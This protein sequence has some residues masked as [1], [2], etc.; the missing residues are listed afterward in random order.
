MT[1]HAVDLKSGQRLRAEE[2][3][4][5]DL[6]KIHSHTDRLFAGLL[7]AQWLVCIAVAFWV[8]PRAWAGGSSS[9]HLH[10][11]AAVVL[12]AIIT[13]FPACWGLLRPGGR[14]TRH[15][16]AVSQM[17][18]SALLIHLSGGRI[19]T[20]FHVF[21]SLALLAAYRDWRVLVTSTVVVATDHALRG[22]FW[23]ESV[24][25]VL[26]AA[27]WRT[28]EHAAWVVFEDIFLIVTIRKGIAEMR[29]IAV[30]RS[31]LEATNRQTEQKVLERTASLRT[32]EERQRLI[33][34]SVPHGVVMFDESGRIRLAN[35]IMERL[36]GFPH[37]ELIGQR[38]D[39]LI[40]DFLPGRDGNL[41]L[42]SIEDLAI[43]P[44]SPRREYS[45]LRA[46]GSRLP[47]ELGLNPLETPE[48]LFVVAAIVDISERKAR[49]LDLREYA[50]RLE[51][52]NRDLTA[53]KTKLELKNQELDEFTYVA[54]HDLQEPI[55][56][57][58]SFS[59][60]LEQD[61]G[62]NLNEAAAGDL[63][64][65]VDAAIRM[66]SLV[67]DLLALSRAGCAA[68][69]L[70]PVPVEICQRDALDVLQMRIRETGTVI[71]RSAMPTVTGDRTLLTQLFQNLIENAIKFSA[72][73]NPEITLTAEQQDDHWILG[74]RDNGIGMKPEYSERIFRPF[75]RLHRRDE[76]EGTG[77]GL[78]IC[79][80]TVERHGG[81]IWVETRPGEGSH[82]KFTLPI[83][84]E[85][86]P[87]LSPLP[88][89]EESPSC[90]WKTIPATR[91]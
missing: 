33:L 27:P 60:L 36:F 41:L 19:E 4:R 10:V 40:P 65:I 9:I 87:C 6:N 20:H 53:T 24:Y 63:R 54:S 25:G 89:A 55:R 29:N 58:V 44:S 7:L 28:V 22:W 49:E 23:P 1:S 74:V 3:M 46:D 47:L 14:L 31:M 77:I 51:S 68:M 75:Q 64:F 30:Q 56:K 16:I 57:L 34:D 17:L 13:W 48:G 45:G 5:G 69:K 91:S 83:S 11:W 88:T 26:S 59:S 86:Q 37:E 72:G 70:E 32:A 35:R 12:G 39:V 81:R 42:D 73:R 82:F 21:G 15:M 78:S 67:Q 79:R 84:G 80:K 50:D 43:D 61:L 66:R 62:G 52:T 18:T 85:L 76:Y 71:H 38:I 90:S 2:L 8:S